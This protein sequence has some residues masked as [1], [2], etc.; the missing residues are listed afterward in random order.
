[1]LLTLYKKKDSA[2]EQKKKKKRY[3]A[4]KL[5]EPKACLKYNTSSMLIWEPKQCK[6]RFYQGMF[7]ICEQ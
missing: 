2:I 1:M 5:D 3:S 4:G 6:P 7:P